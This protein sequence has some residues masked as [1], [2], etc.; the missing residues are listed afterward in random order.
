MQ[1]GLPLP[2]S[3]SPLQTITMWGMNPGSKASDLLMSYTITILA[4][5][6]FKKIWK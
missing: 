3:C 5:L 4:L 6:S 1:S 2:Y